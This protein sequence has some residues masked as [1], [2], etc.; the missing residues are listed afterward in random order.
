MRFAHFANHCRQARRDDVG[1]REH[2]SDRLLQPSEA[3]GANLRT[4][5]AGDAAVAFEFVALIED[6]LA[7]E[8]EVASAGRLRAEA[9]QHLTKRRSPL[10]RRDERRPA[11]SFVRLA[12]ELPARLADEPVELRVGLVARQVHR[13]PVLRVLLPI[14]VGREVDHALQS[15]VGKA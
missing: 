1:F 15:F 3:L 8:V 14:E 4:D 11:L 13:E 12:E 6:G 7:A 5:V 9:M 2:V 10:E